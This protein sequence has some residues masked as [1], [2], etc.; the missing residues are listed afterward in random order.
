MI[1][2]QFQCNICGSQSLFEPQGDWRESPSCT[3]CGSSVRLRGIVHVLTARVLGESVVLADV[4][5]NKAITGLGLSDWEGY[6][7]RLADRFEYVNTFYHQAPQL[8]V[9]NPAP[10]WI[11]TS[12]FLIS[13]DVFEHVFQ[14]VSRAFENAFSILRPGGV[15]VLTVPYGD[16]GATI[17]HYDGVKD[18]AVT[19]LGD[20]YVV[21][22]RSAEGKIEVDA[23]PVFHGGPG[24]T[25][26]MRIFSLDDT[27]AMLADAGFTDVHVHSELD[28]RWGVFPPHPYGL[29]ISA[30]RPHA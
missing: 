17:E 22:T 14:P 23:S 11:G 9:M 30:R 21:V 4:Q 19:Q 1:G 13:S 15:L 29:P 8:D 25:L 20:D 7:D 28:A 5:P 24:T 6:A 27:L 2:A 10:H 16:N 18:L 12:D 26:E 3:G